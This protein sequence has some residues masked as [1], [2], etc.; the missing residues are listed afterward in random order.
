MN[1]GV[2]VIS[3]LI[4]IAD[5]LKSRLSLFWTTITGGRG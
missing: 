2:L 5:I 1:N 3:I 4:K